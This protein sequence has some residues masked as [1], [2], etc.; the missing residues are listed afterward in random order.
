MIKK[1][2]LKRLVL[3]ALCVFT[4]ASVFAV[5]ASALDVMQ[6]KYSAPFPQDVRVTWYRLKVLESIKKENDK[7]TLNVKA[8]SRAYKLY[9]SFPKEGGFR[10]YSDD[11][12]FHNPES[13]N[14]LIYTEQGDSLKIS[15]VGDTSVLLRKKGSD[16]ALDIY[17]KQKLVYRVTNKQ[18]SIGIDGD[19]KI[20]KTR[21]EG[22]IGSKETL[23]GLGERFDSVVR[24]GTQCLLW[25]LDVLAHINTEGEKDTDYSYT[26]IPL[27]HSTNGY[28]VFFNS[29]YAIKADIGKADSKKY[30]MDNYGKT[31]DFFFWTG[32]AAERLEG[33]CKL[34]GY[35]ILPPKWAFSYWA[36]NS[37]VYWAKAS[38]GAYLTELEKM[39]KGY[40][41]IGTPVQSM[42]VEGV[43]YKDN[44]VHSLLKKYGINVIAWHDSG[45]YNEPTDAFP[46]YSSSQLPIVNPRY[47]TVLTGITARYYDFTHPLVMEALEYSFG[48]YL[49]Y[50]TKGAMID[51]ADAI[52]Y[53][54]VFYNGKTGDEMHN[55]YSYYYQKAFKELYEKHH[56]N[57]YILFARA[58]FAGSQSLMGKFLG[59]NPC[60]FY[61]LK[62]SLNAGIGLSLSGFSVWGSD[63]GGLGDSGDNK[64]DEDTYRRWVQWSAF[65]PLFRSHGHTTRTP[66]DYSTGAVRDFQKYFWLRENLLDSIYSTAVKNS[67]SGTVMATPVLAAYP[68]QKHLSRVDDEYMFCD[69]ILVAPVTEE[70]ALSKNV[71]LPN[72][73]W[74]NFWTGKNVKGGD[75]VDTRA[76]EGTI[77]L[78]LRSGSVIPIQLSD[79]LKL[80]GNMENGRVDALLISPAV[81]KREITYNKDEKTAV[82]YTSNRPG[83]GI[84]EITNDSAS[85]SRAVIAKGISASKITV[86]GKTLNLLDEVF[87]DGS[88]GFTVDHTGNTTT[89]WLPEG[90][91]KLSITNGG[92]IS[93]DLALNKTVTTNGSSSGNS[94]DSI[95]DSVYSNYFTLA[96]SGVY[97]DIDLGEVKSVN[98]IQLT[99]GLNYAKG[100][101]VEGSED[102]ENWFTITNV[103]DGT[104]DEEVLL[105]DSTYKARYL[106]FGNFEN[107]K[108]SPAV[109]AGVRVFGTEMDYVGI[110][111]IT[112]N[113]S[114]VYDS[115]KNGSS[116]NNNNGYTDFEDDGTYDED[117]NGSGSKTSWLKKLTRR[118]LLKHF[119]YWI[120]FVAAGAVLVIG[121]GITA[122]I[123]IK[124]RKNKSTAII[125]E[126]SNK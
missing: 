13:Y 109:I 44:K 79:D 15:S 16:W 116:D 89:I 35:N 6:E 113:I 4:A 114:Y 46:G 99:W 51:F 37:A 14:K 64:P 53:D 125:S 100:Y 43:I 121:G 7:L 29:S 10:L 11:T 25:N 2:F 1:N 65:N 9:L 108:R 67:K 33:Y 123:I 93:K 55:P 68:E 22:S 48:K 106:R 69:D 42:F 40:N 115:D 45:Y 17:N 75:S 102:G 124:K 101:T 3:L 107:A 74:T 26:N 84:T 12:G 105:L 59:D 88:V 54:S 39:V 118:R 90:W 28:S 94:A 80:Y 50:G 97:F 47:N 110:C 78:Y 66:W 73:N 57:D 5:P 32:S 103:T 19:N 27:L 119:P 71:V 122:F 112:N 104:G 62:E 126:K 92:G 83:T 87:A 81:D 56:G 23:T 49:D 120:I 34:T 60:T 52:P 24:N 41:E 63:M 36:G 96:K 85:K 70:L 117:G 82:K 91:K 111:D 18:L 95:T 98:E 72:G 38:G 76:S 31:M 21:F 20:A 58:G 86:D 30:T 77:P 61:G 8:G